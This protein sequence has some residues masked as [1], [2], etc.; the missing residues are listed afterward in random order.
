MQLLRYADRSGIKLTGNRVQCRA[1]GLYRFVV[2][3]Q[4]HRRHVLTGFVGGKFENPM[5]VCV[6]LTERGGGRGRKRINLW[7]P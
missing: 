4:I 3:L 7:R 1:S 6:F 5:T 2:K